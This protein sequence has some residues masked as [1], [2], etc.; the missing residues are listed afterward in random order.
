MTIIDPPIPPAPPTIGQDPWG[1][2][3]NTYLATLETRVVGLLSQVD[4]LETQV[5]TLGS[6]V[7]ALGGK[8]EYVF[9]SYPWQFSSSAPPATGS[10]LRLNDPSPQLATM[11]DI[12]VIDSD[13]ADR[14]PVFQ[15]LTIE[16][17]I[18]FND[19]N[20][21]SLNYRYM[22]T[23][24]TMIGPTNASIPVVWTGG[25]GVVPNAKVNVGFLV[26]II[27]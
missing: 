17:K 10:Q 24:P 23:G 19:W 1:E 3:L 25:S 12:R 2:T 13:G 21:A 11:I 8:P 27:I 14:T 6:Q 22:V 15:Q 18:R 26:S 9:N 7:T 5:V 16:D 4:M 20:D